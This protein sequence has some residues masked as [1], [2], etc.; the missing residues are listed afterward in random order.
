MLPKNPK[1]EDWPQFTADERKDY[2]HRLGNLTLLQKG[3]NGKIGSKPF[4]EKKPI[5]EASQL[6][7]TQEAG[8]EADWTPIVV[9]QRQEKLA[10]LAAT[11]WPRNP[12][13]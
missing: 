3:P 2:L 10:D 9:T 5:L 6:I 12:T 8:A 7:L 4:A 1:D 11:V 13:S